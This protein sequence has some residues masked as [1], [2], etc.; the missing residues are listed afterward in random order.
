LSFRLTREVTAGNPTIVALPDAGLVGVIAASFM[1]SSSRSEVVG[2]IELE[3]QPP[4]AVIQEGRVL[5]PIRIYEVRNEQGPSFNAVY[6]D[7]PVHTML[8]WQISEAI[9][10][11]AGSVGSKE[12]LVLGGLPEPNRINIDKPRVFVVSSDPEYTARVAQRAE[13]EVFETGYVTGPNAAMLKLGRERG[14]RVLLVLA[15]A[16]LNYPDPGASAEVIAFVNK[17]CG[18]SYNVQPLIEQAESIRLQLRD[19]MR[20]TAASLS[21]GPKGL[22]LEAP[23]GYIR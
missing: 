8:A 5:D 14:I 15:Q 21:R 9:M 4:I 17:V 10:D 11:F 6:S 7:I 1:I 13:T 19:L 23:P 18:T 2:S 22:E 16:H 20:R 12:L 3:D